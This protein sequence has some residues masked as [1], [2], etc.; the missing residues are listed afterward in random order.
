MNSP[1]STGILGK[2]REVGIDWRSCCEL[3]AVVAN[4]SLFIICSVFCTFNHKVQ[5]NQS[6]QYLQL[7]I[8]LFVKRIGAAMEEVLNSK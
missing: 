8:W 7:L 4:I 6:H 5:N 2:V 1:E 3:S